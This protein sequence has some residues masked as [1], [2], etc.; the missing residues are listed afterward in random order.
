MKHFSNLWLF[1]SARR[2]RHG[3]AVRL[4]VEPLE[5]RLAPALT[6]LADTSQAPN[7]AVV[8]VE[9]TY[10]NGKSF[11]GTG[12][13]IDANSVLTAA[14]T[15][16]S[17][18]DGGWATKMVVW[19][20]YNN[21]T[22]V[23]KSTAIQFSVDPR[24]LAHEQASNAN[25][26]N[27]SEDG[28]IGIVTLRD[29][30]GATAG[31]FA[32]ERADSLFNFQN[33]Q[34]QSLSYPGESPYDGNV[35]Y[36]TSGPIGGYDSEG[37]TKLIKWTNQSASNSAAL[38][39]E[40]G[41][42]S[43]APVFRTVGGQYFIDAVFVAATYP[44]NSKGYAVLLTDEVYNE[45]NA[46][47]TQDDAGTLPTGPNQHAL[48]NMHPYVASLIV[49]SNESYGRVV[50]ASYQTYLGRSPDGGG[51]A[52]WVGR[53]GHGL[54]DEALEANFIGSAEYIAN[55]GGQGEGWVRGM[56]QDLLG[57]P[58]DDAGVQF[59]LARLA[60]GVTPAQ[61]AYGF[62]ASAEREGQRVTAD[63]ATFL[64]R[65]PDPSEVAYW[66]SRFLTG[67]SNEDVIA[68]FISSPEYYKLHVNNDAA[69]VGALYQ[70]VLGRTA[71]PDEID[72]WLALLP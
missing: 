65:V 69:W 66:V 33:L 9:M 56:Y 38:T 55:H 63:Y 35:Q 61:V 17:Q 44:P 48:P 12:A 14:H 57:R 51:L 41:G 18:A 32:I 4:F 27:Y 45:L 2:R 36:A 1:A 49:H 8:S 54:S 16:Y 13:L 15:M 23:A 11:I 39:L 52:Y 70:D 28:D 26:D 60:Q 43:G 19:A 62:A 42:Q 58:P 50:T 25:G 67:V 31:T 59:W 47:R 46:W 53:M 3:A 37:T 6:A 7:S 71:S 72:G 22:Y 21:G 29:P 40:F 5:T 68:G 20:G 10:P 34:R 24:Y 30:M 64:K